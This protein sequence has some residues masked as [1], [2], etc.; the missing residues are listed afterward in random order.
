MPPERLEFS[1]SRRGLFEDG[2]DGVLTLA[3]TLAL[4]R[5]NE[6]ERLTPGVPGMFWI[7]DASVL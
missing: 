2:V 7:S 4:F 6:V 5:V 3:V 1:E